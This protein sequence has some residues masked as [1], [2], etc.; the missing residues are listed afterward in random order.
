MRCDWSPRGLH[1]TILYHDQWVSIHPLAYDNADNYVSYFGSDAANEAARLSCDVNEARHSVGNQSARVESFTS[2]NVPSGPLRRTYRLAVATT[3]EYTNEP[4]LGG[5]SV[6]TTMATI[7]TWVNALNVI[8]E[9]DL[10]VRFVLPANNDQVIFTAEPDNLTGTDNALMVNEIRPIIAAKIG[11]A[12]YDLG[13]VLAPGGGGVSYI[14]VVCRSTNIKGGGVTR[15]PPTV[16]VGTGFGLITLAHEIGHQ[17]SATHTFSDTLSPNCSGNQF[18]TN[19]AVESFAG[20]TIMSYAEGCTQIVDVTAPHFYSVSYAQM[21]AYINAASGSCATVSNTGNQTPTLNVGANY[22]IP[23]QTPF[24]LTAV[25]GDPD[26]GDVA[27]LNYSWEQKDGGT[28]PPAA[29]GSTGPLF[30]PFAP[31]AAPARTFPSLTYIL[32]NANMPP[33]ELLGLKTAE[34]LPSVARTM[35]FVCMLRDGRGG[36]NFGEVELTVAAAGPFLVT[37]PNTATTWTGGTLQTVTWSVNGTNAA[38]INCAHVRITLSTDGGNTFPMTLAD[39]APNTGAATVMVPNRIASAQARLKVE[40]VGNV[41]FDISD[42]NFTLTLGATNTPPLLTAASLVPIPQGSLS[43]TVNLAIVSDAETV[44]G[45]LTVT[46]G[47]LPPEITVTDIAN[48]NGTIS[49]KITVGCGAAIGT[50]TIPLTVTDG[51]GFTTS[52]NLSFNVAANT[53]PGLGTYGMPTMNLGASVEISPFTVQTENGS[54]KSLTAS[55][56]NFTGTFSTNLTTG[57]IG[58]MSAAPVGQFTVTLTATDNC[59]AH[60]TTQVTLN[61]LQAGVPL[62]ADVSPRTTGNGA[63]TIADW[64]QVGRFVAGLDT[65]QESNE[66]QRADCAPRATFGD[67]KLTIA[68]WVQAGRYAA[69]LD[70]VVVAAGPTAPV[71]SLAM[72][73]QRAMDWQPE[74]ARQVRALSRSLLRGQIASVPLEFQALGNENALGFTVNYDPRVLSFY[75]ATTEKGITLTLNSRQ[76]GQLGVLMARPTA[77]TFQAGWQSLATLE[78]IPNGGEDNVTTRLDFGDQLTSRA[79]ADAEATP[80]SDLSFMAADFTISGRAAAQVSAASYMGA[81]AASDSI[82]SAFGANLATITQAATTLPLPETLGG[83]RVT[84]TDN[85]GHEQSAPLFFISSTQINY[86]LPSE[87]SDGLA[88]LTITNAAGVMTRGLL[89]IERVAPA[90]FTADASGKGWAAADVQYLRSDGSERYDRIAAFDLT[91]NRIVGK[92]I[93]LRAEE[94]SFLLLYGTGWQHRSSLSAVTVRIGGV[95]AEVL[96]VGPQ[97]RYAGLDQLNVRIPP[98]LSGRGVVAVEVEVD[99]YPTPPVSIFIQ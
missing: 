6:A 79:G 13:Q 77:Q 12:N 28:N 68:D 26:A 45:S 17:F 47:A 90:L 19:T 75:R 87:L 57:A 30:R 25:G 94:Q 15:I 55:A 24:T 49:A 80:L 71:A 27:N 51:G 40:A 22:T 66:Y 9:R 11:A 21:A 50:A 16:P 53:P 3:V 88:T 20:M 61:V 72:A 89:Q 62:E 32:N 4:S 65:I 98:S 69:G 34:A 41:F 36:V 83:T 85:A 76:S 92:P 46:T 91:T 35:D 43:K 1:A 64:T 82:M 74:N 58:I 96:Y 52:A 37:A 67:G 54:L 81:K 70:T 5:G 95:N 33:N 59:N 7:N 14:G 10:S 44:A 56:P 39:S 48:V 73:G 18:P 23:T 93:I 60:S 38:P 84:I 63:V 78:F 2:E 31:A 99:G 29:D 97:G 86:L 8:Y 42:T